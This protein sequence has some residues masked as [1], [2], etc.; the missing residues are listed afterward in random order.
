[1]TDRRHAFTLIE[2]L[3]VVA[4]IGILAGITLAVIRGL[5][6]STD[7]NK[8][9]SDLAVIGNALEQF[10]AQYG[11]YPWISA[12]PPGGSAPAT[13]TGA[14]DSLNGEE[15]FRFLL[16]R[17]II[18]RNGS[19]RVIVVHTVGDVEKYGP[20]F[21]SL[22]GMSLSRDPLSTA[23][24]API[25][26]PNAD[27]DTADPD[28]QNSLL[29]PWGSRYVYHY[30]NLENFAAWTQPSFVLISAGP[31]RTIQTQVSTS[32]VVTIPAGSDDIVFPFTR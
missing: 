8:A 7:R 19:T 9:R 16:G 10:K 17:L 5:Q 1:M 22:D 28:F 23:G 14:S 29:D 30:R 25:P 24:T 12:A 13:G 32:G 3:T 31:D 18:G 21:L 27:L 26:R 4:I 2:L 20:A 11:D 15:L 6:V